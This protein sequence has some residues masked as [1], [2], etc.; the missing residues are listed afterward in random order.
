[1]QAYPQAPAGLPLVQ[2]AMPALLELVR[3]GWLSLATQVAKTSHR[4][5]ELFAIA[6]RGFL[7]VGYW[8]DLVLVSELEHPG[9]GTA[10]PHLSPSNINPV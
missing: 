9:P 10:H 1:Q 2:H 7:R 5:A 6:D 4:V 8:A 3:E